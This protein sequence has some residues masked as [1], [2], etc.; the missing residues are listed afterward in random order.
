VTAVVGLERARALA[1]RAWRP[2]R[3]DA[4]LLVTPLLVIV[5][6]R[7]EPVLV[8][9]VAAAAVW[10]VV[11]TRVRTSPWYW[12]AVAAVVGAWQLSSFL[13]HDDHEIVTT[14]WCAALG[15][16]LLARERELALARAAALLI[17]LVFLFAVMWKL[18]SGEFAD[19]RFFRFTLVWD[20]RFDHLSWAS[21]DSTYAAERSGLDAAMA[22]RE[23]GQTV[24]WHEGPRSA[25]LAAV[26]TW[27]GIAIEAALA[28]L[29]LV[30]RP[31][32]PLLRYGTLLAFMAGTY[33]VVPIPGFG[34]LLCV[35]AASHADDVRWRR[36]LLVAFGVLLLLWTPLWQLVF[37]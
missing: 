21:G 6:V 30:P 19:G 13:R 14:Y 35:L 24:V 4:A 2:T 16:S 12:F 23:A 34:C 22:A 15:L 33:Y 11:A 32:P 27:W 20:E 36:A 17:G 5:T 18:T 8:V 3:L 25:L 10:G 9:I 29:F 31:L 28:V 7:G 1:R 37:L 26:M